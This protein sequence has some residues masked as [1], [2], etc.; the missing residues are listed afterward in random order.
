LKKHLRLISLAAFAIGSI[1]VFY[2]FLTELLGIVYDIQHAKPQVVVHDGAYYL[3]LGL[4]MPYIFVAEMLAPLYKGKIVEKFVPYV[5]FGIVIIG[6]L[7]PWVLSPI[8]KNMLKDNGYI[9]CGNLSS[10]GTRSRFDA[11]VTDLSLCTSS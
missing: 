5:L 8:M 10:S 1:I 6:F 3:L 11:W 4:L 7:L 9:Y 2:Y